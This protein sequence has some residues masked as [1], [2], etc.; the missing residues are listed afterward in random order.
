MGRACTKTLKW[1]SITFGKL[2]KALAVSSKVV[3]PEAGQSTGRLHK[4]LELCPEVKWPRRV[5]ASYF[6][7]LTLAADVVS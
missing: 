7:K 5:S 3:R 4:G 6:R 1:G 2:P